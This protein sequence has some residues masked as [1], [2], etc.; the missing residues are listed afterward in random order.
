ML[1]IA[2]VFFIIAGVAALFGFDAPIG[3]S[4][5]GPRIIFFLSII[6]FLATLVTGLAVRRP[7]GV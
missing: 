7:R 5:D 1:V 4:T 3:T 6:F 2:A